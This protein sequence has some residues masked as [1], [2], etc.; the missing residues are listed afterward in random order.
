MQTWDI[1]VVVIV[2]VVVVVTVV[3]VVVVVVVIVVV[4]D[5]KQGCHFVSF[6][7]LH[8]CL[9]QAQQRQQQ[10]LADYPGLWRE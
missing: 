8:L 3:V 7:R 1:V 9:H 2:V 5:K 10:Q 6:A 4:D